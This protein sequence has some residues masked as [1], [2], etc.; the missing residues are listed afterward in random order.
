MAGGL[1]VPSIILL[2]R[3]GQIVVYQ[4]VFYSFRWLVPIVV[5]AGAIIL[6]RDWNSPI[7]TRPPV[8]SEAALFTLLTVAGLCNLVQFPFAAPVY[9]FYVA[10]LGILGLLAV[11]QFQAPGARP[12]FVLLVAFYMVFCAVRVN[13]GFIYWMGHLF[14]TDHQTELLDID[15]G[16]I[17]VSAEDKATYESLV[18]LIREQATGNF[19]FATPDSPEVYFLT[20]YQN[21]TPTL[22]D[23]FDD[24]E[25][26]A[27]RILDLLT[28]NEV[29]L[30]V[31]NHEP[32][33]SDPAS[34]EL[35]AALQNA[36]PSSRTIS[37][38][39]VRWRP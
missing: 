7:P 23:F 28:E 1:L 35:V 37:R 39:E 18:R 34:P 17:R 32:G 24:P 26:R 30:V 25:G 14:V 4:P 15:R 33:F 27:A 10:A 31:L 20:G 29:D 12:V 21:P 16:G 11:V 22:F 2:F 8:R 5:V 19:I 9:F 13:R 38:F 36:Y 6:H 3:S